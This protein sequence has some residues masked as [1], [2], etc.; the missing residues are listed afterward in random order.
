MVRPRTLFRAAVLVA[1]LGAAPAALDAGAGGPA[2]V[3]RK[4]KPL[5]VAAWAG[6][7]VGKASSYHPREWMPIT[8]QLVNNTRTDRRKNTKGV[9]YGGDIVISSSYSISGQSLMTYV[10]RHTIE[11]ESPEQ[12]VKRYTAGIWLQGSEMSVDVDVYSGG[13]SVGLSKVPVTRTP[14]ES[15]LVALVQG[16]NSPKKFWKVMALRGRLMQRLTLNY[17]VRNRPYV[18]ACVPAALP[19]CPE[20][21]AF[22]DAVIVLGAPEGIFDEQVFESLLGYAGS[23]GALVVASGS[24][25]DRYA[26]KKLAKEL[27]VF[28]S[29]SKVLTLDALPGLTRAFGGKDLDLKKGL[30]VPKLAVLPGAEV[31][32]AEYVPVSKLSSGESITPMNPQA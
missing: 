13:I 5:E 15:P 27:G 11:Y 21:Y 32:S 8:I 28:M 3:T 1:A 23:G 18:H 17:D 12:S 25:F 20:H 31:I 30:R 2:K 7:A 29:G 10:T 22:A 4:K 6:V 14:N 26:S 16:R 19:R 24:D 9:T